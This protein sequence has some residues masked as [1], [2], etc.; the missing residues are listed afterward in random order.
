M[1]LRWPTKFTN[2]PFFVE[3]QEIQSK[4]FEGLANAE[5]GEQAP[6]LNGPSCIVFIRAVMIGPAR[7]NPDDNS[8][9]RTDTK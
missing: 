7:N 4:F 5:Q 2:N 1:G 6:R 3:S 8:F 9:R